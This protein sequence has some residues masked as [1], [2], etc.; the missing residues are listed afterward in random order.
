[1]KAKFNF[2]TIGALAMSAIVFGSCED[3][4]DRKPLTATVI[5]IGSGSAAL[6]GR[7]L[8]LYGEVRNAKAEPYS[9]DG[10]QNI[11]WVA[12]NGFRS[13]DA[14]L[15]ADPGAS[16]WHQTYDNFVYAKD[17]WGA[18][19]Y[20]S[21]H[22]TFIGLC[23]DALDV[24]E[25][26]DVDSRDADYNILVAEAKF[27]RAYGYFD[28]VR[29]FGSVPLIDFKINSPTDGHLEK[30]SVQEV[31]T[32]IE[33]DLND[34]IG[35]LPVSWASGYSGRLTKAAAQTFL[36]KVALYQ[37][38]WAVALS[39]CESVISSNQYSL[40]PDYYQIFRT[41]GELG[42]ESIFEIQAS[43]TAGDGDI[44][45]SRFGQCQGIR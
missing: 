15:V 21:A 24:A 37:Q 6:S 3:F 40:V 19:L 32:L 5:D 22:Y 30:S 8:G 1:M 27:F 31:Y 16:A 23:N 11:P 2:S 44:Y 14:E 45:W 39:N 7:V 38:D 18:G 26:V 34:A 33:N 13:D 12:M 28:L 41:S 35:A 25:N 43:K 10:F 9:G 29:T 36:A 17:D 4:L 42:T 20:W